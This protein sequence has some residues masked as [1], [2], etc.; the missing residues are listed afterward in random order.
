MISLHFIH[1]LC[2]Y[3]TKRDDR[4]LYNGK[5]GVVETSIQFTI[6]DIPE[7]SPLFQTK[8]LVLDGYVCLYS[9]WLYVGLCEYDYSSILN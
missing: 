1:L 9:Y 8:D 4:F 6:N 7:G 2:H 3:F 5:T